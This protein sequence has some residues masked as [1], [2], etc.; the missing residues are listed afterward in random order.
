[1]RP[2]L[3]TRAASALCNQVAEAR[4]V[5][6]MTQADLATAAGVS[7]KTINT[8]ERGVFVPSTILS[9]KLADVLGTPVGVLFWLAPE[10]PRPGPS[11]P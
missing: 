6:G 11:D 1:M 3:E 5:R 7:R 2:R 8:V 4:R 10:A 9:L